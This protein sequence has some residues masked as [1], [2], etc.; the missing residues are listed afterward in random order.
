MCGLWGLGQM[1]LSKNIVVLDADVDVQ[2]LSEVAW[3]VLNNVDPRRDMMMVDGPLDALDHSSPRPFIGS[4]VG[5]DA[6][7]KGP[8]DGH[9]REWP[10]DIVMSP[11]IKALVDEK[12]STYG[13]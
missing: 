10:D 4:K 6:T 7:R 8:R 9:D 5:I 11:A 1:M 12:W 13:I 3:R 2:N